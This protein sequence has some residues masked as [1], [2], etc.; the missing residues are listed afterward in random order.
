MNIKETL[1][2]ELATFDRSIVAT[3]QDRT[4]LDNFAKA[5]Q[6]SSDEI[7]TQMAVQFGYIQAL[8]FIKKELE[9]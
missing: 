7:L 4:L 6:G 8:K 9:V 2:K 3:P 5:N 1:E